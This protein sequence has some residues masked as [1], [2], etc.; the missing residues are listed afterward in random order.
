MTDCYNI[1][2]IGGGAAGLMSAVTAARSGAGN[3]AIFESQ[4]RCG[5]KILASGG[6][7]CN[8]TNRDINESHYCGGSKNFIRNV[9]HAFGRDDALAFFN[10]IGVETYLEGDNGKYFPVTDKAA[11]VTQAL[12]REA[13]RMGV[14][15]IPEIKIE[16]TLYEDGRFI[17]FTSS[18]K[19]FVNKLII[20]AGGKSYPLTGSSGD[21]YKFARSFGHNIITTR[22]AL[23]PLILDEPELRVLSGLTLK[24]EIKIKEGKK[25]IFRNRESLLFTHCGISGPL[26]LNAS[27]FVPVSHTESIKLNLNFLEGKTKEEVVSLLKNQIKFSPQKSVISYFKQS[28]PN[29]LCSALFKKEGI[30][31]AVKFISMSKQTALKLASVFTECPLKCTGVKGYN[32]AEVTA[33]GVDLSELKYQSMESRLVPGLYFA[34]EVCDVDGDLGGYNFQ[35]AWS[36]GYIAG[37]SAGK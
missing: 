8:L 29:S 20:A 21:G 12:I 31:E 3:V 23:T 33:G 11:S 18:G 4:K 25:E 14:E 9:L 5:T 17:L 2:I 15:I 30:D 16:Q 37:K 22:P 1:G 26:G 24:C 10:S 34:G 13:H 7:R 27:R 36:S 35:W 28:L 19:I 32:E 6:T